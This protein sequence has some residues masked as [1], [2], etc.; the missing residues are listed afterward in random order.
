MKKMIFVALMSVL[1][2]PAVQAQF[3]LG[4]GGGVNFSDARIEGFWNEAKGITG[5]HLSIQPRLVFARRWSAIMDLQYSRKGAILESLG[6]YQFGV[7]AEYVDVMPQVEYRLLEH[8]G[9]AVGGN[10]GWSVREEIKNDASNWQPSVLDI[11]YFEDPDL[12]L[13]VAL[14]GY[15]GR[16]YGTLSYCLGLRDVD[17]AR[18]SDDTGQL[19]DVEWYHRN[20][21]IGIGY[22]LFPGHSADK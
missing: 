3:A 8:F 13:L 22:L 15:Y 20:L 7:R 10:I 19:Y 17:D 21:Q 18:Y 1:A 12:G 11:E 9:I 2:M 16:F 14:R 6:G 5:Y 4:L